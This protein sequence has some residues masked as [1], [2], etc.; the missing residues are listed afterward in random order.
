MPG[1]HVTYPI[2]E[3]WIDKFAVWIKH[4]RDLNEIRRMNR[5]DFNL[6]AHD[7]RISPDE[8][9]RLVEAGSHSSDEMPRM[10]KALGIDVAALERVEPLLVRDMQQVCSLCRDKAHCNGEL[11]GGPAAQHCR[12]YCRN[13]PSIDA[14]GELA[15]H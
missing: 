5:A 3:F 11:A 8:L 12:E 10:L 6:I 2:V 9:D 4:R 14:L 1:P 13:A 15:Q 7:L